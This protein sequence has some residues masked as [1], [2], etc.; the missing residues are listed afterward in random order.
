VARCK[1]RRCR[2]RTRARPDRSAAAA[3]HRSP[4]PRPEH[5]N[6]GDHAQLAGMKDASSI[7]LKNKGGSMPELSAP[8]LAGAFVLFVVL[9]VI[10]MKAIPRAIGKQCPKCLRRVPKGETI[11]PASSGPKRPAF[12]EPLLTGRDTSLAEVGHCAAGLPRSRQVTSR[13][14]RVPSRA[15]SAP[16][17]SWMRRRSTSSAD[18]IRTDSTSPSARSRQRPRARINTADVPDRSTACT[19]GRSAWVSAWVSASAVPR[20]S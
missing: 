17:T 10:F 14:S 6:R 5:D 16:M 3:I 7:D 1:V 9:V 2:D 20:R 12:V 15:R 19:V 18:S 4:I 8:L 13:P 11:C